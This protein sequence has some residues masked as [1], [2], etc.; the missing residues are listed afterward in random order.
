MS[1]LDILNSKRKD[2]QMTNNLIIDEWNSGIFSYRILDIG[3][4]DIIV[5]S[6]PNNSKIWERESDKNAVKIISLRLKQLKKGK[7]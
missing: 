4:S 3:T 2:N 7:W 5:T 1:V 6:K